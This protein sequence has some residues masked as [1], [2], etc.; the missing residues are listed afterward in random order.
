MDLRKQV[1]GEHSN[2]A[3]GVARAML[4]FLEKPM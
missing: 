4:E 2:D 3:E 1:V